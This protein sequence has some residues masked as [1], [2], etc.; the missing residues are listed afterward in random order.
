MHD[1]IH[2]RANA[3]LQACRAR[4]LMITT[5]ESCTGGMVAAALTDIAGSSAVVERG[6]VTYSNDAKREMLGVPGDVLEQF[7]A[8]SAQT[9][10]AMA[11]GALARSLAQIAV[12]ITGVAGP[13][14]GT[15]EKPVGLVCFAAAAQDGRT[16]ARTRRFGPIGR[17]AVR[18]HSVAEAL[19]M[20]LELALE[21]PGDHAARV[22]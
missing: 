11:R 21:Y 2:A 7:G 8:V 12:S 4:A 17:T 14:G 16:L 20:M 3:L 15:A 13:G 9:A 22:P 5:A 1:H 6:F 18:E 10:E 19:E